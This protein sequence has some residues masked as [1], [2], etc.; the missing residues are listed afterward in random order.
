M[1]I[2]QAIPLVSALLGGCV[3]ESADSASSDDLIQCGE[4]DSCYDAVREWQSAENVMRSELENAL[5]RIRACA[6]ENATRCYN[7]QRAEALISNEQAA[8]LVWRD[9]HCDVLAFGLE[10]TSAHGE[11]E[12]ACRTSLTIERT[13]DLK[14]VMAE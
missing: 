2:L 12:A 13:D 4:I 10:E 9:A 6:P 8:W 1:K 5:Q 7:N 14:E 11:I 3:E